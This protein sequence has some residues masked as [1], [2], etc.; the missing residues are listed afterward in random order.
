M[1]VSSDAAV[2]LAAPPSAWPTAPEY[3]SFSALSELEACPRR[4]ALSAAAYPEVWENQGYP[5]ALHAAALEGTVAHLALEM[6]TRALA[7]R[8]CPSVKDPSAIAILKELG[9]FTEVIRQAI[10]RTLRWYHGNPRAVPAVDRTRRCLTARTAALRSRVQGLLSRVRLEA[11]PRTGPAAIRGDNAQ[12]QDLR[13]EL[14]TGSHSEVHLVVEEL[15]WK[16]VA[17]LIT[18]SESACE[19]RDFK[20]GAP[21]EDHHLQLRIYAVLWWLDRARNPSGRLADRLVISYD[22]GDV[23]VTAPS[24]SMLEGLRSELGG[25]RVAAIQTLDVDPPEAR[26][27][28]TTCAYCGVRHLCDAYWREP[29]PPEGHG[30]WFTDVQLE[31]TAQHGTTSWDGVVESCSGLARGSRILLRTVDLPFDL[32]PVMQVRVLN[33]RVSAPDEDSTE[34]EPAPA[35]ASMGLASEIFLLPS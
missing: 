10:D 30:A 26:P 18:L 1:M 28:A 14:P 12:H 19:I 32:R 6:I 22:S 35:V 17:D 15:G 23:E 29:F 21:K 7:G 11:R 34:G 16:G 20:T 4:W 33:V 13:D 8:D 31:L 9:G 27:S 25:R 5:R 3:I 2:W 24:V